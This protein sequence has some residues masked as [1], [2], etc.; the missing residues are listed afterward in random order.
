MAEISI[1]LLNTHIAVYE[2][3]QFTAAAAELRVAQPTV[4]KRIATLENALGVKL[5]S[6]HTASDVVPTSAGT[7][8]YE[9]AIV[10]SGTWANLLYET[11]QQAQQP[12]TFT[13]LLSHTASSTLLPTILEELQSELD[14]IAFN[15]KTLNSDNIAE[16][17]IHKQ[18]DMGIVEK[19]INTDLVHTTA[20]CEDRLVLAGA[21][22]REH[23]DRAV[24]L[25]REAGSGVRYY[26]DL[27]FRISDLQPST[28]VELDSN[29]K[30]LAVL[31]KG[32]GCSVISQNSVPAGVTTI[33]LGSEFIRYFYA[34]TPKSGLTINQRKLADTITHILQQ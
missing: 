32:I 18:A 17:I 23:L 11:S 21:G 22:N 31:A 20:L 27:F 24:W 7:K 33:P 30:I 6:R 4:S 16:A 34:M 1:E 28:V 25:V 29:E 12:T 5:F 8:L 26:T 2:T 19:T 9:A 13:L 3:R 15:A 14:T 10:I